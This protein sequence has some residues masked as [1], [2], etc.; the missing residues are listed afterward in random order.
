MER[1]ATENKLNS[2]EKVR[3][4]FR[5]VDEPFE[6]GTVLTPTLKLRRDVAKNKFSKEIADMYTSNEE[7]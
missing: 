2:L 1:L 5:L 6:V 3:G 7:V 4:N